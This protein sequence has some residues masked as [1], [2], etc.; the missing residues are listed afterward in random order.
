MLPKKCAFPSRPSAQGRPP[1]APQKNST[2]MNG[3]PL[4]VVAA[5]RDPGVPALGGGGHAV[6]QEP[7]ERAQA[8]VD[9]PEADQ[10][11][12]RGRGRLDG[13]GDRPRGRDHLDRPLE[14]GVGRDVYREHRL[15]AGVGRRLREG[16]RAVDRPPDLGRR[17]GPLGDQAVAA[18]VRPAAQPPRPLRGLSELHQLDLGRVASGRGESDVPGHERDSQRFGE[19]HVGGIVGGEIVP[20]RPHPR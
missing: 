4:G 20:Q 19:S 16:E 12:G 6:G 2:W 5:D 11:P 14:A 18:L 3:R 17:V 7:R 13:V 1:Q 15:D 9:H 10:R 8:A